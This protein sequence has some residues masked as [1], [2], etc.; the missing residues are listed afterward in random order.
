MQRDSSG[1]IGRDIERERVG[2]SAEMVSGGALGAKTIAAPLVSE[3][4]LRETSA[5]DRVLRSRSS[6][7]GHNRMCAYRRCVL[8]GDGTGG[9]TTRETRDLLAESVEKEYS[10]HA[11]HTSEKSFLVLFFFAVLFCFRLYFLRACRVYSEFSAYI[12]L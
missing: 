8:Y 5:A 12:D 2:C 7:A 3:E 9:F 11:E 1:G 10:R 4:K 6:G